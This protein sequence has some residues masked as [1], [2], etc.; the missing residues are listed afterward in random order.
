MSIWAQNDR[1][2]TRHK[3]PIIIIIHAIPL[4][5]PHLMTEI[6]VDTDMLPLYHP[7]HCSVTDLLTDFGIRFMD[8][9]TYFHCE[10]S[11]HINVH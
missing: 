7:Y 11:V 9:K 6:R 4:P 5:A 2:S 10:F 3:M 1:W 8:T